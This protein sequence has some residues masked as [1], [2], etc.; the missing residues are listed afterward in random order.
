M[1][2][3]PSQKGPSAVAAD[4][5]LDLEACKPPYGV[6]A[7]KIESFVMAS[8]NKA[9]WTDITIARRAAEQCNKRHW[10]IRCFRRYRKPACG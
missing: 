10:A 8:T 6:T 5:V 3:S 7:G 4:S 2:E 1:I 9:A